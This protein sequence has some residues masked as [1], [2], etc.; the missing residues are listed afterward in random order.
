MFDLFIIHIYT[1]TISRNNVYDMQHHDVY[2]HIYIYL[3]R[4][5]GYNKIHKQHS[6]G[7]PQS[8]F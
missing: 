5:R 8:D 2:I 6:R 1:S 3:C 7:N 4:A